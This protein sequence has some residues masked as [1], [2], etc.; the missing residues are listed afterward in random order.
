MDA[1]TQNIEQTFALAEY[2]R[3][4]IEDQL[5]LLGQ[6]NRSVDPILSGEAFNQ[7]ADVLFSKGAGWF[8]ANDSE[9]RHARDLFFSWWDGAHS[10]HAVR[11]FVYAFECARIDG[12][13]KMLRALLE[14]R[15]E[16]G[17]AVNPELL[18]NL[19]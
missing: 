11:D 7:A 12:A 13:K 2:Q 19:S 6:F 9:R 16:K 17:L 15:R 4:I 5:K 18:S 8:K 10:D 1:Y 3:G 14:H